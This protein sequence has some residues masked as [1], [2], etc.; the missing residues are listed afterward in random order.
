M[1]NQDQELYNRIMRELKSD[2]MIN[3]KGVEVIVKDGTVT[4]KGKVGSSLEK[5]TIEHTAKRVEGVQ[6][7][8]DNELVT[9]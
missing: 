4:F 5:M 7:I 1:M 8:V 3:L 2:P 6:A 9:R